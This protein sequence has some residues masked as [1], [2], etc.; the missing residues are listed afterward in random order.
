MYCQ[1]WWPI[2]EIGA[3]HLTHPSAHTQQ[4]VVNTHTVN[5][6]PEQWAVIAPA[7]G[8][9]LGGSVPC[10]RA[11]QSWYWRWREC[12]SFTIPTFNPCRT[13]DSNPQP[14]DYKSDSLTIRPRLP[15][16]YLDH[17][18]WAHLHAHQ[19]AWDMNAEYMLTCTVNRCLHE[20][21]SILTLKCI[22]RVFSD[23]GHHSLPSPSFIFINETSNSLV[24]LNLFIINNIT[25]KNSKI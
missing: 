7:P 3:L 5:T 4:W 25:R 10:S 13:W 17:G 8:E 19:K 9:Q 11:P 12:Y 14:L 20:H 21:I 22:P 1:V 16:R 2:L 24:F 23:P 18:Q 6:H 15:L